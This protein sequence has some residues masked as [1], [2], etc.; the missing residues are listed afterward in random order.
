MSG[1]Q[2]DC[3]F[4]ILPDLYDPDRG[5]EL[6]T[7]WT[8]LQGAFGTDYFCGHDLDLAIEYANE[9]NL[10]HSHTPAFVTRALE[11]TTGLNE[12]TFFNA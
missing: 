4:V 6:S 2:A 11:L 3:L 5:Y 7:I 10:S 12:I 9:L 8:G 1:I